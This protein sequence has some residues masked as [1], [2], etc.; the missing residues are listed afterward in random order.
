MAEFGH[1]GRMTGRGNIRVF[2]HP[3]YPICLAQ[4]SLCQKASMID[5]RSTRRAALAVTCLVALPVGGAQAQEAPP[6]AFAIDESG[7]TG[8][9]FARP[10]TQ[11]F[12]H[13]GI[14]RPFEETTLVL[15]INR[16][17]ELSIAV[18]DPG[19]AFTPESE[20]V[21]VE[22]TID[23]SGGGQ[24]LAIPGGEDVL[25]IQA[26]QND[27]FIE[28]LRRGFEMRIAFGEEVGDFTFP[29]SGTFNALPALQEC[30]QTANELLPE[31]AQ[32]PRPMT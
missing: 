31:Q 10:G 32:G 12:S 18:A 23:N 25:I 5:L 27:S 28:A 13:C 4:C 26:G 7:W 29:L 2:G 22:L 20:P 21:P 19:F 24:A 15:S 16:R 17:N 9:A 30:I 3:R 6:E 8:G 1:Y 14:E 11:Q